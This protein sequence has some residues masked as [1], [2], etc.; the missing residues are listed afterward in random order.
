MT[1]MAGMLLAGNAVFISLGIGTMLVVAVAIIGSVTVLPA[2]MAVLGDR[3]RVGQGAHHR[4]ATGARARRGCG[5]GSSSGCCVGPVLSAVLATGFLLAL[6]APVLT[7]RTVDPGVAGLPRNLPIMQTYD[8]IEA[9]FPGAPMS[10]LVV[11]TA[12]DVTA[13]GVR[14]GVASLSRAVVC[15]RVTRWAARSS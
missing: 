13:P 11:V 15:P 6:A 12:P 5:A 10:A 1:A 4:Q 14:A 2:V 3:D 9:A 8:R 7:M